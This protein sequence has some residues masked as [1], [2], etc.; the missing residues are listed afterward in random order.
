MSCAVNAARGTLSVWLNKVHTRR[1]FCMDAFL[2]TFIMTMRVLPNQINFIFASR[3]PLNRYVVKVYNTTSIDIIQ[4]ILYVLDRAMFRGH[5]GVNS[6]HGAA[7]SPFYG[8]PAL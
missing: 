4:Q 5:V 1:C 8:C 3:I 2:V 6:A 7:T